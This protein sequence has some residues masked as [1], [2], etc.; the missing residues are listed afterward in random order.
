MNTRRGKYK[1]KSFP[2]LLDSICSYTIVMVRIVENCPEKYAVMHWHIQA[3]NTT[4]NLKVKVDLTLPTL[5]ATNV[6]T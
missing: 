2:I 6:V 3:G 1:F 4:T 5:S